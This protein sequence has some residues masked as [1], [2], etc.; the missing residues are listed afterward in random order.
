[1]KCKPYTKITVEIQTQL[2]TVKITSNIFAVCLSRQLFCLAR[3]GAFSI[4]PGSGNINLAEV[5]VLPLKLTLFVFL[6]DFLM[7]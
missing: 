4:P 2:K 1:M 6:C 5:L 7:I 3:I